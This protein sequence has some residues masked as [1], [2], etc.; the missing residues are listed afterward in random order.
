[1][2]YCTKCGK[3]ISD[4]D[5]KICDECRNNVLSALE[6]EDNNSKVQEKWNN[7]QREQEST[8]NDGSSFFDYFF[9]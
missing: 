4:G 3:E 7:S 8:P 9:R 5:N 6:S 1:M 2:Q